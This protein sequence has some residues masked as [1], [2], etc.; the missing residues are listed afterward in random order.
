[1]SK[2]AISEAEV[3]VVIASPQWST[4]TYS[5]PGGAPRKNHWARIDGRL[6][7]VTLAHADVDVVVTVVAP[8]EE[9]D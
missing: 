4:D 9:E 3:E 7:R 1:M 2:R 8:E 6:L 5:P